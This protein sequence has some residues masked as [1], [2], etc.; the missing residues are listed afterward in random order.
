MMGCNLAFVVFPCTRKS[1]FCIS[2]SIYFRCN[3]YFDVA[4]PFCICNHPLS[5]SSWIVLLL[6]DHRP[7]FF[8]VCFSLFVLTMWLFTSCRTFFASLRTLCQ[9]FVDVILV[10][11]LCRSFFAAI[12]SS[13]CLLHLCIV[14]V[15]LSMFLRHCSFLAIASMLFPRHH[16]FIIFSSTPFLSH[17][18]RHHFFVA[19]L[20]LLFSLCRYSSLSHCC[21]SFVAIFHHSSFCTICRCNLIVII[22]SSLILHHRCLFITISSYVFIFSI[23]LLPFLGSHFFVDVLFAAALLPLFIERHSLPPNLRFHSFVYISSAALFYSIL[24]FA[25]SLP[26][27][28]VSIFVWCFISDILP[29][30]FSIEVFGRCFSSKNLVFTSLRQFSFLFLVTIA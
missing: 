22:F 4:L 17:R 29:L 12:A 21:H 30:Q 7:V 5:I 16:Y 3:S 18:F 24:F 11:I 2:F 25:V 14:T 8:I 19:T 13:S 23:C 6:C 28:Y 9:I 27:F 20:L 1:I 10:D 15:S 26:L